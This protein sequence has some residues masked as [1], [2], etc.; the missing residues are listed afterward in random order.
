MLQNIFSHRPRLY[1]VFDKAELYALHP[2][3]ISAPV[4][5]VM[6]QSLLNFC[7]LQNE[8]SVISLNA[9]SFFPF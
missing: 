6:L 9:S 8:E 4:Y 3:C 5:L 2:P 7:F 1:D